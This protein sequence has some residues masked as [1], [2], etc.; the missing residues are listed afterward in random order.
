M[1]ESNLRSGEDVEAILKIAL[2][3][4]LGTDHDLRRRL[5]QSAEELGISP[6]ALAEAERQYLA[7]Q[8]VDGFMRAKKRGMQA[9]LATYLSV[10]LMLH[11]IW[12]I[13][14]FGDFYW[15]GIVLAAWGAGMVSHYIFSR[16]RPEPNDPHYK[17]WLEM[18]EPSSYTKEDD[19]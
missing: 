14:M 19:D 2:R 9:H 3:N 13:V 6:E 15:P 7:E 11:V 18:G 1:A 4:E 5:A 16:Q 10:N 12:A 8:K 17:M